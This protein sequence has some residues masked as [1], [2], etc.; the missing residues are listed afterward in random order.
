MACFLRLFFSP[1]RMPDSPV[2][3]K[4]KMKGADY[5]QLAWLVGLESGRFLRCL[6]RKV[7][8]RMLR[9]CAPQDGSVDSVLYHR[10]SIAKR[11]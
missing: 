6:T 5:D 3:S 2:R 10:G 8:L 11:K 1:V 4:V 9:R 7:E